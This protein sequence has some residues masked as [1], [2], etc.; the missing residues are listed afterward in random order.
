MKIKTSATGSPSIPAAITPGRPHTA[1]FTLLE[2]M[3]AITIAAIVLGVSAPAMQRMYQS[4][5]YRGAVS[6]V[7]STLNTARYTAIRNGASTDV[8][9]DPEQ[10]SLTHNGKAKQLPDSL[11]I[12]VLGT[13]EL[14]RDGA[15]VIRFYENGG[16]SGGFVNLSHPNGLSVQVQ[17]DWLLG[18][19][20]LC[21][22]DCEEA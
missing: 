3:A 15:G 8:L 10:R 20:S 14:N 2:L 13:R 17:V 22:E 5:Q 21:K 4:A 12:E 19:V 1:G 9:I 11:D 16:S 7:V 18:K 6:D